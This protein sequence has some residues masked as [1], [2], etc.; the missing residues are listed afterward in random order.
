MACSKYTLTNTGST[1]VNFSYRRCDDSLW[2]YQVELTPGQ[3]K[4]IWTINGTYTIAPLYQNLVSLIN[5]GTFPPVNAT[6]TPTATPT[7][8]PTVT[9]TPSITASQTPTPSVT[10][11]QT[12]TPTQTNTPTST[13]TSTPTPTNTV[14]PTEPI[15]Y[16]QTVQCHDENSA[17][18]ACNCDQGATVF[19]NGVDFASSTLAFSDPS[20]VNTGDP[21]GYYVENGTVY[22]VSSGCGI[23]CGTGSAITPFGPCGATPTPTNTATPTDT[24]TVTPTVTSTNTPTVTSTPT[25]TQSGTPAVTPTPTPSSFG[26]NKFKVTMFGTARALANSF[27]LTESPYIGSSGVG[28]SATTGTYPLVAGP[29]TVYGNHD[30]LNTSTVTFEI[31]SSGNSSVSIFYFVNGSIVSG[32]NNSAVTTGPNTKN[33]FIAGPYSSSDTIEFQ[34]S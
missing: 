31:N 14:T 33:L 22:Q 6:A 27:T 5:Q 8:T 4:N 23:G 28:F 20:G 17:Q 12:Q 11:S 29:A 16:S 19:T 7:T 24:P 26:T 18:G 15:R 32:L 2:E 34:I 10:A 1:T 13:T 3:T 30:A 21:V 25:N 9:P